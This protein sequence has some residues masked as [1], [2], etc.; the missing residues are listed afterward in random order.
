MIIQNEN[1]IELNF[2][3]SESQK[4][5]LESLKE[6]GLIYKPGKFYEIPNENYYQLDPFYKKW[7]E[8]PEKFSGTAKVRLQGP[9][10]LFDES[11]LL[12]DY[13][14]ELG[15]LISVSKDG[16]FLKGDSKIE[17]EIPQEISETL[18]LVSEYNSLPNKKK[19]NSGFA[20]FGQ[21]KK[22]C[23][24]DMLVLDDLL[25]NQEVIYP[26]NIKINVEIDGE[27]IIVSPTIL[28]EDEFTSQFEKRTKVKEHY[29]YRDSNGVKKRVLFD[30]EN[31]NV[32]K[33]LEKIKGKS[34]FEGEE[35]K[36]LVD[37]PG[38]YFNPDLTDVS[39]LFGERVLGLQ[40]FIPP[41]IPVVNQINSNWVPGFKIS[42]EFIFV[43]DIYEYNL[44]KNSY[45]IALEGETNSVYFKGKTFGL[46][47]VKSVLRISKLI[48]KEEKEISEHDLEQEFKEFLIVKDNL[49]ELSFTSTREEEIIKNYELLNSKKFNP[50][51]Q[52][53][54]HQ[55]EGI[56]WLQ[57]TFFQLKAPGVLLADDM[58]LGKTLQI[59]YFLESIADQVSNQ[60]KP[61]LIVCPSSLIENW[62]QEYDR[63]F[64]ERSYEKI[65]LKGKVLPYL[66]ELRTGESIDTPSLCITTYE[67]MRLNAVGFC[68]VDWGIVVLDEAQKIKNPAA[69]V[70]HSAKG[71]KAQFKIAMTG[72]PVENSLLD[73]WCL[74][75]FCVPGILGSAKLFNKNVQSEELNSEK[76]REIIQNKF[77]RRLKLDVAKDLPKKHEHIIREKFVGK[78]LELYMNVINHLSHLKEND[79][80]KGA[81]MLAAIHEMKSIADHAELVRSDNDL[82]LSTIADAAKVQISLGL[83]QNIKAKNEK[84]IIF[85]E[86]RKMQFILKQIIKK[87]FNINTDIVNGDVPSTSN[88][89]ESKMTRQKLVDKFQ[90]IE[91][92]NVI[93]MS[94]VAAGFGLN[95]VGANHVIHYSRHWNP[96][97]EQ[98]ATDRVYRIGQTKDVHIYYPIATL[99]D[100]KPSF[101]EIL[102]DRLILKKELSDDIMFPSEK[103]VVSNMEILN[104]LIGP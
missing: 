23:K 27:K 72:T 97:K 38:T 19:D 17:Y 98:Q 87:E 70:T 64:P 31:I 82:D 7:I 56:A 20:K 104:D 84:V 78:Q 28:G 96:A 16:F 22:S 76:I 32:H 47:S 5:I 41:S 67:T 39:A 43:N 26:E 51:F 85:T 83:L 61:C 34:T 37:F 94:P 91:G 10:L 60:I 11:C 73:L 59:L 18:N 100:D 14:D 93:I 81:A 35:L 48:F 102:N 13:Y 52:L 36:A 42:D 58:G 63:F 24:S 6:E 88:Y 74:M 3:Y 57:A 1:S 75:D 54:E 44:L 69:L 89:N 25:K 66:K 92:F 55:I 86:R 53:K 4:E 95:V 46:D 79:L 33:E 103:I 21:L 99:S 101:D 80:L 50:T 8:L 15:N 90:S 40:V 2:N 62:M 71:L 30:D 68:T 45:N 12:V 29:N 9:G 49:E 65:I 77:L